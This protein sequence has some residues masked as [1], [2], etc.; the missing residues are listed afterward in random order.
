MVQWLLLH[1]VVVA[2]LAAL[3]LALGRWRR[4]PPAAR[5]LLWLL[6]LVKLLTPPVLAWPWAL[7]TPFGE[8][9]PPDPSPLIVAEVAHE[10]AEDAVV[11]LVALPL[12]PAEV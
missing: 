10:E 8:P 7:P 6:V 12:P 1:T 5:H 4:L 3:A 2:L 9:A 11:A